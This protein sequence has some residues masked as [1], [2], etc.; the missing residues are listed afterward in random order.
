MFNNLSGTRK[1]R[2]WSP[3]TVAASVGAHVLVFGVGAGLAT[4]EA[5]A[6]PTEEPR[7]IWEMPED[8]VEVREEPTPPPPA[9]V[10]PDQPDEPVP[11]VEGRTLELQAPTEVPTEIREANPNET[12]ALPEQYTGDGPVGN[13]YNENATS[14]PG[15]PVPPAPP[16]E[17]G[18]GE[19]IP[20]AD[21]TVRPEIR[22]RADVE[23]LLRNNY[24][25]I[26]RDAGV[27][28]RVTVTMIIDEEGRVE[29]G[30]VSVIDATHDGFRDAAVRAAEKFRFRPA[31]LNGRR[32]SVIVAVPID[33]KLEN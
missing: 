9:P 26:L 32:V 2:V 33:W 27:V 10:Q 17:T 14:N 12:P 1:R 7:I 20:V 6:A 23:R 25:P 19:V 18:D 21:A 28:G 8:P 30:S 31:E 24:P 16:T 11:A 13:V 4:R 15:T 22:N 3:A 5:P 29:P